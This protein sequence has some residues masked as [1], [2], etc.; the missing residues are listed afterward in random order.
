MTKTKV[1]CSVGSRH[2]KPL[3]GRD[4]VDVGISAV[5]EV[6]LFILLQTELFFSGTVKA[7]TMS[8]PP[9]PLFFPSCWRNNS[10]GD[11]G[12]R[13][14][15]FSSVHSIHTG[16][17]ARQPPFELEPGELSSGVRP[18]EHEADRLRQALGSRWCGDLPPMSH[19]SL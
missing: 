18:M 1:H 5:S 3:T 12:S 6:Y 4:V 17:G 16:S 7:K 14:K 19:M 8:I 2:H 13:S 15:K 9:P 10:Q 11:S